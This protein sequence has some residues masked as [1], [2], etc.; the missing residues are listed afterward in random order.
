[1]PRNSLRYFFPFL[2]IHAQFGLKFNDKSVFNQLSVLYEQKCRAIFSTIKLNSNK[3]QK[4][5]SREFLSCYF[6]VEIIVILLCI[7]GHH[8]H[9]QV[10]LISTR[11]VMVIV[12][13][14]GHGDT[15]S[16]LGRG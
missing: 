1:M 2:L 3:N 15:S 10:V 9:H 12:G 14:N 4:K 5:L 7:D 16:N 11:G 6:V 8:V 13:G